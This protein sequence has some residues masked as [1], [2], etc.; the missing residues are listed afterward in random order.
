MVRC[1]CAENLHNWMWRRLNSE[2]ES[3]SKASSIHNISVWM[4][5]LQQHQ[6]SVS[7]KWSNNEVINFSNRQNP[8]FTLFDHNCMSLLRSWF[9]RTKVCCCCK[10]ELKL[11]EEMRERSRTWR[12]MLGCRKRC[13][14][15]AAN[16]VRA[17]LFVWLNLLQLLTIYQY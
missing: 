3:K 14:H 2:H 12:L 4:H 5:Q 7:L 13:A 16:W 17:H 1:G 8:K 11:G 15:R 9:P 6:P 10:S